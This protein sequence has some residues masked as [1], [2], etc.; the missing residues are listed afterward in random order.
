MFNC[1]YVEILIGTASG[2]LVNL[3]IAVR[4]WYPWDGNEPT[5]SRCIW[6]NLLSGIRWMF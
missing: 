4:H 2:H 1:V 3:F 5:M 6:W